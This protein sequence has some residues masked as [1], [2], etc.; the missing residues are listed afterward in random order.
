MRVYKYC[1]ACSDM[2]ECV[3]ECMQTARTRSRYRQTTRANQQWGVC[4]HAQECR[5]RTIQYE[6]ELESTQETIRNHAMQCSGC[7]LE[8]VFLSLGV[9][10]IIK[11]QGLSSCIRLC[12]L[13]ASGSIRGT[14]RQWLLKGRH[15]LCDSLC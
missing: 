10:I 15:S 1:V 2:Q 7:S 9:S 12:C 8:T 3:Q 14:V 4:K 6:Q 5:E 11:W 13:F